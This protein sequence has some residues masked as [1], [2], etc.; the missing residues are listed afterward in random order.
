MFTHL[1]EKSDTVNKTIRDYHATPKFK[2]DMIEV[3]EVESLD[4][5]SN[6]IYDSEYDA[7]LDYDEES[8]I[9]ADEEADDNN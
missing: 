6:A 9:D 2:V 5:D 1:L 7:E 8:H 4:Y 3:T